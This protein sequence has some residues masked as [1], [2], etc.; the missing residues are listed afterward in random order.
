MVLP[1]PTLIVKRGLN[2]GCSTNEGTKFK[3]LPSCR[4]EITI[5]GLEIECEIKGTV[6]SNADR[7]SGWTKNAIFAGNGPRD[8]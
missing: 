4:Y 6:I 1:F 5:L 2:Y 8:Y 3:V 7:R